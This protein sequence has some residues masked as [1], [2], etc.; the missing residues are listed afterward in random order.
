METQ[1]LRTITIHVKRPIS[2]KQANKVI[3][4][5]PFRLCGGLEASRWDG[6][7]Q[8]PSSHVHE[9]VR[10]NDT[11]SIV[12]PD[13][14]VHTFDGRTGVTVR[15]CDGNLLTLVYAT[16][17]ASGRIPPRKKVRLEHK[18]NERCEVE[19]TM[20]ATDIVGPL[21]DDEPLRAETLV[22]RASPVVHAIMSDW[23]TRQP[24][25]FRRDLRGE[26]WAS[27][28]AMVGVAV[29]RTRQNQPYRYRV[30]VV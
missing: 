25:D 23:V 2:A 24:E 29:L 5:P 6:W 7:D 13:Q 1:E 28:H 14:M 11:I 12:L 16:L 22:R 20:N 21:R 3:W 17:S 27:L 10:P 4:F 18:E 9:T 8:S 19:L 26:E 30:N 15:D